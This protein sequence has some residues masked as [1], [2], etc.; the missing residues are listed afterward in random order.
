MTRSLSCS[1]LCGFWLCGFRLGG[2]TVFRNNC[3]F[4]ISLG[5]RGLWSWLCLLARLS[6]CRRLNRWLPLL[7][8]RIGGFFNHLRGCFSVAF[9]LRRGGFTIR[10]L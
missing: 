10:R 9:A 4:A 7:F 1:Y 8:C 3:L 5:R 6:W 2:N